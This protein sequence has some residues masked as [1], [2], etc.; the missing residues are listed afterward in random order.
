M[1]KPDDESVEC[2]VYAGK[3]L[4]EGYLFVPLE[5][6]FA[7]VPAALLE[8]LGELSLVMALSLGPDRKLA[9]SDPRKV[10]EALADVGYYFQPPPPKT[11]LL[12]NEQLLR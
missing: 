2:F 11:P 7:Q 8:Q 12:P 1:T 9:R 6:D 10:R 5:D 3:K 4:S